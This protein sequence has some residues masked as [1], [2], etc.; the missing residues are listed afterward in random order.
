MLHVF[1]SKL[2]MNGILELVSLHA[3]SVNFSEIAHPL[4]TD[5]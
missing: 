3:M 5:K 4:E 1:K 2:I